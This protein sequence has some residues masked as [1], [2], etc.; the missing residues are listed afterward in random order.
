MTDASTTSLFKDVL[1]F[2]PSRCRISRSPVSPRYASR[3][4]ISICGVKTHS[5]LSDNEKFALGARFTPR[6]AYAIRTARRAIHPSTSAPGSRAF[7]SHHY[8]LSEMAVDFSP[9]S[10]LFQKDRPLPG[11]AWHQRNAASETFGH[12]PTNPNIHLGTFATS[13]VLFLL[14]GIWN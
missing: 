12:H 1:P 4:Q 6:Y 3:W 14:R 9:N 10:A 11:S 8:A 2:R 7:R 5:I 13:Q